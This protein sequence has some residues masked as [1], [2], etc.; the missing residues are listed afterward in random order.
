MAVEKKMQTEVVMVY[1][2]TYCPHCVRAKEL[3]ARRKVEP[4]TFAETN[5]QGGGLLSQAILSP[6]RKPCPIYSL[7]A[8]TLVE[9]RI[10]DT[11]GKYRHIKPSLNKSSGRMNAPSC[12]V[13][14]SLGR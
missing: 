8:N 4:V 5:Q 7:R 10:E 6:V 9:I 1:S 14:P 3:L 11:S 12:V 2:K 13:P